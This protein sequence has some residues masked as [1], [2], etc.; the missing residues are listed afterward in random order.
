[1]ESM[2][3]LFD[4][5]KGYS[6]ASKRDKRVREEE[7]E[8]ENEDA[9]FSEVSN[10]SELDFDEKD[11]VGLQFSSLSHPEE[12]KEGNEEEMAEQ[13]TVIEGGNVLTYDRLKELTEKLTESFTTKKFRQFLMAFSSGVRLEDTEKE[14][15]I[16]I[17]DTATFQELMVFAFQEIP[18]ILLKYL[19]KTTKKSKKFQIDPEKLQKI[20]HL[21]RNYISNYILFLGKLSDTAMIEFILSNSLPIANFILYLKPYHAKLTRLAIKLWSES[22]NPNVQLFAFILIREI[23]K[24][25]QKSENPSEFYAQILKRCYKSYSENAKLMGW[26][27]YDIIQFMRNCYV[28][29]L[30]VDLSV[31]YQ[32]AFAQIRKLCLDLRALIKQTLVLLCEI[33]NKTKDQRKCEETIQLAR[34]ELHKAMGTVCSYISR[35]RHETIGISI[36]R[37]VLWYIKTAD[38]KYKIPPIPLKSGRGVERAIQEDQDLY[39]NNNVLCGSARNLRFPETGEKYRGQ[40]F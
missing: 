9:S 11:Y 13:K 2:E 6:Y 10:P 35:L 23:A 26:K 32:Q 12:K 38:S 3:D 8:E 36:R 14:K 39:S 28:E 37:A 24:E 19:A 5:D 27:N 7:P 1:M 30:G 25:N 16:V 31:A 4:E 17:P 15:K 29:L 33:T 20:V 21:L 18:Q 34:T 22:S 40:A